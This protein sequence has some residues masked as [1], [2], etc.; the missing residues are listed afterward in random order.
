MKML[1]IETEAVESELR[2]IAAPWATAP[3]AMADLV[4]L[5][6]QQH[7]VVSVLVQYTVHSTP[8][9][10]TQGCWS[11]RISYLVFVPQKNGVSCVEGMFHQWVAYDPARSTAMR[12]ECQIDQPTEYPIQTGRNHWQ[13]FIA[14]GWE[15][16][17]RNVTVS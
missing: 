14:E 9:S 13:S 5:T 11:G 17:L 10:N 6:G 4:R 7:P 16:Y 8:V 1:E 12:V 2:Q 15:V 3:E